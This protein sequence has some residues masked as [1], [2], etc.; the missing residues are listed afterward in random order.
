LERWIAFQIP[1]PLVS[2]RIIESDLQAGSVISLSQPDEIEAQDCLKRIRETRDEAAFSRLYELYSS[3]LYRI[4]ILILKNEAEAQDALQDVFLYVW[5]R[6]MGFDPS[7]G[8]LYTWLCLLT[9]SKAID[10]LRKNRRLDKKVTLSAEGDLEPV[11]RQLE[12]KESQGG[13]ALEKIVDL[14]RREKV[15]ALLA[16]LS[17]PQAEVLKL[18]YYEGLSQNEISQRIGRPLGTVKT[19]MRSA[20]RKLSAQMTPEMKTWL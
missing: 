16:N 2:A 14:E 7:R 4:C 20:L 12:I 8:K 9:R 10:R 6:N 3:I 18:A 11:L 13:G 5:G 1:F 19:Q 17:A 15:L